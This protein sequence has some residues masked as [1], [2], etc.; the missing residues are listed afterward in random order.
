[1]NA[2]DSAKLYAMARTRGGAILRDKEPTNALPKNKGTRP[3]LCDGRRMA[4]VADCIGSP[5]QK[6]RA[7][8]AYGTGKHATAKKRMRETVVSIPAGTRE[9]TIPMRL[10]SEANRRD[11]WAR[12]AARVKRQREIVGMMVNRMDRPPLPVKITL[13]RIGWRLM[14]SD[15]LVGSAKAVRDSI[16]AVYGVNDAS[17]LYEWIYG[18]ECGEYGVRI[19]LERR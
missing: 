2:T 10:E 19:K 13:T 4:G 5:L 7:R 15:N 3:L 9:I 11:H 18:Q 12:K 1:M 8:K 17:D 6:A 14:D 16:A